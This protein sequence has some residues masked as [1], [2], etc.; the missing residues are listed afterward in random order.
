[1]WSTISS[2]NLTSWRRPTPWKRPWHCRPV[3]PE[4]GTSMNM[5]FLQASCSLLSA[6]SL[7]SSQ[8]ITLIPKN[9]PLNLDCESCQT[10]LWASAFKRYLK[11]LVRIAAM[12]LLTHPK[13]RNLTRSVVMSFRDL[14]QRDLR[15]HQTGQNRKLPYVFATWSENLPIP[16]IGRVQMLCW[17]HSYFCLKAK[18]FKSWGTSHRVRSLY[19]YSSILM[20]SSLDSRAN[21]CMAKET[22]GTMI[23]AALSFCNLSKILWWNVLADLDVV[24]ELQCTV[25]TVIVASGRPLRWSSSLFWLE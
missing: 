6:Y 7:T 5:M 22:D 13:F 4:G 15:L 1:M 9:T 3:F 18:I 17:P 2:Q 10:L 16:H 19:I 20:I 8:H 25:I 23:R 11:D 12:L 24:V 14:I 21:P